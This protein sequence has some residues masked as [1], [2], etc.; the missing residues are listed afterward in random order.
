MYNPNFQGGNGSTFERSRCTTCGKQPLAKCLADMYGCFGCVN[1]G[2]NMIYFP[3]NK[4]KY[5]ETKQSSK[6]G[7]EHNAQNKNKFY[8]NTSEAYDLL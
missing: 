5:K 7:S 6:D 4:S 8:C 2:H 3:N 1:N